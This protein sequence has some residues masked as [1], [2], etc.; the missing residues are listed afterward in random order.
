[1]RSGHLKNWKSFYPTILL[2]MIGDLAMNFITYKHP[3]W[4][5]KSVIL[6]SHTIF[7]LLHVVVS[8]PCVVILFLGYM[9]KGV[10]KRA[11]YV[12]LVSALYA[13]IEYVMYLVGAF[14]Y[15]NGWN[16]LY[17]FFFDIGLFT[18]LMI[19][20]QKPLLAWLCLFIIVPLFLLAVKFP[21]ELL[22]E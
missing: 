1:M 14:E 2:M 12:V 7:D 3:F 4:H 9:P 18:I 21:L 8:F 15:F 16:T 17:S 10:W 5:Y 22:I 19:H 11:A 6:H 13:S 20:Y